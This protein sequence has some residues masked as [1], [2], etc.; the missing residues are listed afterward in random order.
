MIEKKDVEHL[1][2]L[3]R[4]DL[5]IE[6]VEKFQNDLGSIISY[7]D[8]IKEVGASMDEQIHI[9]SVYNVLREDEN[10]FVEGESREEIVAEFPEQEDGYLK[11]KKIL[12]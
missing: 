11:V 4:L 10:P 1:A 6:E 2:L 7:V 12:S 8:T 3:S 9:G 5:S